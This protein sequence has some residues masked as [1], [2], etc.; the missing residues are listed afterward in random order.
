MQEMVPPYAIIFRDGG[1]G[2]NWYESAHSLWHLDISWEKKFEVMQSSGLQ[3]VNGVDIFEGDVVRDRLSPEDTWQVRWDRAE[4]AICHPTKKDEDGLPAYEDLLSYTR[5][6][7]R[8]EVIGNIYQN[9][10]LV[11]S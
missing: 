11:E 2:H 10:E 8:W 6:N 7:D 3:D 5:V 9:P 4:F 1:Y